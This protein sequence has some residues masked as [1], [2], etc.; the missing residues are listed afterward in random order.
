MP[1]KL[2]I[3]VDST[4]NSKTAEEYAVKL[5]QKAP[6]SVVLLNILNTQDLDGHGI[7]PGLKE[8]VLE[9]KR[10]YAE[11]AIA[12]AAEAFKKAGIEYEKVIS[13]GDPSSLI[14]YTAQRDGIDM[15]LMAESGRSE[16]QDWYMGSVTNYVLYRCTVPVLLVKH[17][18]K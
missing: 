10:I 6:L 15:V 8:T 4:R 3:P 11:R 12:E 17:P 5:H 2:L 9:K 18:R 16:F 7:D 14:C 13:T 1:L